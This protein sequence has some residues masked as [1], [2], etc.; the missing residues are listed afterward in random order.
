[1][2]AIIASR[3]RNRADP[4]VSDYS[5]CGKD[6]GLSFRNQLAI[7]RSKVPRPRMIDDGA[8]IHVVFVVIRYIYMK[9]GVRR[10]PGYTNRSHAPAVK[11]RDLN[12]GERLWNSVT[13]SRAPNSSWSLGHSGSI[14]HSNFQGDPRADSSLSARALLCVVVNRIPK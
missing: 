7:K 11:G 4:F 12:H 2:L 5:L 3:S 13:T 9:L 8:C 1:M 10:A 14:G 6:R